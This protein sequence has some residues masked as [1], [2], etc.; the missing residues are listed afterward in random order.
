MENKKL[1]TLVE[2]FFKS[3]EERNSLDLDFLC[4]LIED[5]MSESPVLKEEA[6]DQTDISDM[7]PTIKITEDWGKLNKKDRDVIEKFTASLGGET[8]SVQ[9]KLAH[10]NTIV[11][12]QKE[13]ATISEIL[14]T[15][16]VIEVLSSILEEFTESAGGFIFEGF[17]AGLFGGQSVQITKPEDIPGMEA[18][19]KPITDV[20]LA[21]RHYSLKLL[22][23]STV[24][25]G[26][27]KNMV[28]HFESGIDHVTYLDARREGTNLVFSEFDITLPTFLDVFYSPFAK[29]AKKSFEVKTPQVLRNRMEKLADQI[30]QI[31]T[32]RK[33]GGFLKFAPDQFENLLALED[34]V[35]AQAGPFIISYSEESFAK[36]KKAKDLFGNA[37]I[38]NDVQDAIADGNKEKIF[39]ALH[40]TPAY[41][42]SKQF[43]FTP[44]QVESIKSYRVIGK[45]ELGNEALKKT[46]TN[47]GE[48]LKTTIEPVYRYLNSFTRN[49]NS[50]FLSAPAATKGNS[51]TGYASDAINDA[52]GL[53]SST[54][55][56]VKTLE[57]ES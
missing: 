17:L 33:I 50:Y 31:R 10:I 12:G 29:L 11:S 13:A 24:V 3:K 15:M 5:Q 34:D 19:G 57:K 46:W 44:G 42:K 14:T 26:S 1:D 18:S 53:K 52:T 2:G 20:V 43:N 16:M 55:Q 47:Y 28:G 36:S 6:S 4:R 22:G 32:S 7:L 41:T 27:F 45:L 23:P 25:K 51:R 37:R 54:D 40:Q 30:Y 39:K 38:F 35:L 21:G 49:I 56:A 8:T 48:R 9:E